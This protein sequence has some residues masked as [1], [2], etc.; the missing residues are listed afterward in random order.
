VGLSPAVGTVYKPGG[1]F[2]GMIQRVIQ[3]RP[4]RIHI[5]GDSDAD[6]GLATLGG[7]DSGPALGVP[8]A[9]APTGT[10]YGDSDQAETTGRVNLRVGLPVSQPSR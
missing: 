7:L 4:D 6:A 8:S 10:T 1:R 2:K 3:D 5:K 9:L